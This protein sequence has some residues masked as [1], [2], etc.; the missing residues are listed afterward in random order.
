[1][2]IYQRD[3]VLEHPEQFG[4]LKNASASPP[5]RPPFPPQKVPPPPKQSRTPSPK[6]L[7]LPP[8]LPP[9]TSPITP[10]CT[11]LHRAQ[12]RADLASPCLASR[13]CAARQGPDQTLLLPSPDSNFRSAP[14]LFAA[15]FS[16]WASSASVSHRRRQRQRRHSILYCS[17]SHSRTVPLRDLPRRS[18]STRAPFLTT[19]DSAWD[20]ATDHD[21]STSSTTSIPSRWATARESPSTSTAKVREPPPAVPDL[22]VLVLSHRLFLSPVVR[23]LQPQVPWHRPISHVCRA[24]REL[25]LSSLNAVFATTRLDRIIAQQISWG[26]ILTVSPTVNLNHFRLLRV[27]GRGA[28]G[29]VRI[30]ERKDTNLSFALKYIRKDEGGFLF[31][32]VASCCWPWTTPPPPSRTTRTCT[33]NRLRGL[34]VWCNA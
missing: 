24:W 3:L 20:F 16:S 11:A 1:M 27:V 23:P 22:L 30:V 8:P 19:R 33:S 18:D 32:P 14:A 29:K 13:G 26:I 9:P 31:L 5:P 4:I 25:L 2:S 21:N 12:R 34:S 6:C 7:L 15:D 17:T 10:N 28:F